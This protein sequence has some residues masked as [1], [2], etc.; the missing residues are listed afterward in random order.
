M[1]SLPVRE[2]LSDG[3]P[4]EGWLEGESTLKDAGMPMLVPCSS[5]QAWR[6]PPQDDWLSVHLVK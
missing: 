4:G 5:L 3:H 1:V 2:S 6:Y